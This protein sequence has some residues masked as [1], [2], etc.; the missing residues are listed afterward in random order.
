MKKILTIGLIGLIGLMGNM[1]HAQWE[2][3]GVRVGFGAATLDDDLATKA[4]ILGA[5]VGGYANLSFGSSQSIL[6]EV[7]YLQTGLNI[8]RKGSNFQEVLD[9]DNTLMIR[10]GY[11]HSYY[12]QIPVLASVHMELPIRRAGHT[13]GLFL[14]PTFN[15]GLFG[16]YADRKVS[17][18]VSAYDANY[19]IDINGTAEDRAVFN[20]INRFDVGAM[21]G[22]TYE[23][24]NIAVA[25]FVDRGFI[26]TSQGEDLLRIIER[27]QQNASG[28]NSGN[29]GTPSIPFL[30]NNTTNNIRVKIPNGNNMSYMVSLSYR[31][32]YFNK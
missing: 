24:G 29:S 14:G 30:N 11:Y 16:R 10:E 27:N 28:D 20:H 1:A 15:V 31:L 22:V 2:D 12:A 13:V 6:G 17:P 32:G 21:F 8:V 26:A 3:Y 7:F 18:G 5:L 25:L 19:D 9:H 23:R 4:P